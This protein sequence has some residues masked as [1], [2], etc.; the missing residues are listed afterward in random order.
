MEYH[1]DGDLY[2]YVKS[3]GPFPE[4]IARGIAEQIL[5]GIFVLHDF[6]VMHRDIKP[7]VCQ[8]SSTF[9]YFHP[10]LP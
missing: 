10:Y 6:D 1:P 9:F 2:G 5:Q 4:V 8:L 3:C 7:E